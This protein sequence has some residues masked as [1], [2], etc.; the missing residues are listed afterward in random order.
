[1]LLADAWSMVASRVPEMVASFYA[2]LM[3]L[4]GEEI[5]SMFPS[6]MREQRGDFARALIQWV[7]TDDP[8]GL[9]E[10]LRQLGDD[11]RKFDV[12]PEHYQTAGYALVRAWR[13]AA[14]DRWTEAHSV[15]VTD[16]YVRLAT[17]MVQGALENHGQPA[18]WG[19]EVIAHNRILD[20]FA[21]VTVQPDSPYPY[22]P[23]QYTTVELASRPRLWRPMSIAS[24]PRRSNTFD[25]HVREVPGGTVS[26][27]L[28]RHARP[29][30]R[31]R[32]GPAR[33]GAL[34]VEPGT[35]SGLVCVTSGTGAAPIVAVLES[36]LRW[37]SPP[38][39]HAYVGA[40]TAEDL[41]P[42][43]QMRRLGS[44]LPNVHVAAV[45]SDE[46]GYLGLKGRVSEVVPGL[47]PW[48]A[49]E[50]DVL[51][52]G[53]PRMTDEAVDRF[54]AAGV[55]EQRIHFDPYEVLL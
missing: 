15:A 11:H 38:Q 26:Q 54:V 30:D 1:M 50:F 51:L 32:I 47:A 36:A 21:V 14:G 48:A 16:A 31:M 39:I 20:D 28:V 41:F 43:A 13:G 17:V 4:G 8:D 29:G 52:S 7:L 18:S 27:A 49:M 2:I 55:P 34:V 10:T 44:G 42:V 22:R 40:R 25:L 24:A 19:A 12:K 37:P 46:P 6:D 33:G 9:A 53:P 35:S 45:V 3:A 5:I 23:G